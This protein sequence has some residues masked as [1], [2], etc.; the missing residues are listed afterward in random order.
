MRNFLMILVLLVGCGGSGP[1]T[2]TGIDMVNATCTKNATTE[3]VGSCYTPDGVYAQLGVNPCTS[4]EKHPEC[5]HAYC[6]WNPVTDACI[7]EQFSSE[8]VCVQS[9]EPST[10]AAVKTIKSGDMVFAQSPT[11]AYGGDPSGGIICLPCFNPVSTSLV[12]GE[13]QATTCSPY[14][15]QP[16]DGA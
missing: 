3:A 1:S 11:Y 6:A 14:Q 4:A 10:S 7:V 16:Q 12:C 5:V 13:T 15:P 2:A 9:C 8:G